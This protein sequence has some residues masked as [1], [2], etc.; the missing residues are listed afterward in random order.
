[1]RAFRGATCFYGLR[2][3]FGST[4]GEING[5]TKTRR[6]AA[7]TTRRWVRWIAELAAAARH[8]RVLGKVVMWELS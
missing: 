4:R 6:D 2:A 1:M 3:C 5:R 8:E 7:M